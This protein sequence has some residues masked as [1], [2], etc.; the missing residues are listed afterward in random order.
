MFGLFCS[1]PKQETKV[2]KKSSKS[3]FPITNMFTIVATIAK[4]TNRKVI[5]LVE[6][7]KIRT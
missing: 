3:H 1:R 5:K 7:A 6:I 4:L 2:T